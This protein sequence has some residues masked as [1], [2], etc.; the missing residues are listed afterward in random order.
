MPSTTPGSP[1][2]DTPTTQCFGEMRSRT[3]YHR[4]GTVAPRCGS[5]ARK[6][7]VFPHHPQELL[8]PSVSS[9]SGRAIASSPGPIGCAGSFSSG[10][11]IAVVLVSPK[12]GT[13][14]GW[15]R[16]NMNAYHSGVSFSRHTSASASAAAPTAS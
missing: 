2:I 11:T 7:P 13:F 10:T 3:A 9:S 5:F 12:S 14:H 6:Q 4:C 15:F 16:G 1:G 8:A